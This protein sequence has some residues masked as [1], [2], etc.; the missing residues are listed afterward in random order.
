[1]AKYVVHLDGT[2]QGVRTAKATVTRFEQARQLGEHLT[3]RGVLRVLAGAASLGTALRG[4][5]PEAMAKVMPEGGSRSTSKH[6]RKRQG[7]VHAQ[8]TKPGNHCIV[9]DADLNGVYGISDQIVNRFCPEV[10]SGEH[11]VAPGAPW[12]MNDHFESVPAGFVPAPGATTPLEDF[13]QKFVQVRYVIDPNSE[14]E[15]TVVF[16]NAG[17]L[18]TGPVSLFPGLPEDFKAVVS[19]ATLGTLRPLPVGDHAVEVYWT[20]SAQ[21]CDGL[22]DVVDENCLPGEEFL[23]VNPPFTVTPGHN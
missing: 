1:M 12:F 16:P 5:T 9:A 4:G 22:G 15:Q 7:R 20:L 8:K 3:R 11:W 13:V 23:Y 14:H 6:R 10:G 21:H 18:F 2:D 19:P 17:N